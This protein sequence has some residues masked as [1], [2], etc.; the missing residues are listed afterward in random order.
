M[1]MK[2]IKKK[3]VVTNFIWKIAVFQ[4]DKIKIKNFRSQFVIIQNILLCVHNNLTV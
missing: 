1:T 3:K 2:T 4:N